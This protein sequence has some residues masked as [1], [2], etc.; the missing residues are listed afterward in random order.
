[1]TKHPYQSLPDQAYWR[2][3]IAN[4]EP[5]LVDPVV[6]APFQLSK[7][8]K[9]ATAGSCFA[10]HIARYLQK[11]GYNYF[12]AETA[13]P[14][15]TPELAKQFG[16]GEYSARYGNIY[17]S[18]QLLQ[19][20]KRAFGDFV[21][22][23]EVW[24][25]QAGRF[26]DPFRT[27]IHPNGYE[28]KQE[29]LLDQ[30]QHLAFV[31]K[32]FLELDYFVFTLGLTEIWTSKIDGAAFPLCPG[33]DSGVFNDEQYQFQNLT[34]DDVTSDMEEFV[35]LLRIVNP[36]A[37]IILTV[38]PV[39]LVATAEDRHVLQS[40]TYSKAVLRVAAENI[41]SNLEDVNYFPSF[42]IIT[43][44]Y[45][46]GRYFAKDCRSVLERGVEHVMRLFLQ[47]YTNEEA[48]SHNA[49]SRSGSLSHERHLKEMEHL[50]S[51]NCAEEALDN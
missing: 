2:R 27:K 45:S 39:P 36:N 40:T 12:V 6:S 30:K 50:V 23:D 21:P 28:T 37:K 18:R 49:S 17:S 4:V 47:H 24:Q 25:T 16:Y 35:N 10:Q 15:A 31:R 46:R 13:H 29:M 42:E 11:A 26:V 5:H 43:G 9:I 19:L 7:F 41:C 34:T 32:V 8:E 1:M 44:D 20:F 3:A 14:L 48:V 33:V 38:S 22:I 51:V